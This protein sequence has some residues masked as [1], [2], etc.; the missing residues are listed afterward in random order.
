M[1]NKL[2]FLFPW[3]FISLWILKKKIKIA[4]YYDNYERVFG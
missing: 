3:D 4:A 2:L 1:T